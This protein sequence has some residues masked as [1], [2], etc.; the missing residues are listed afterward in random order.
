MLCLHYLSAITAQNRRSQP[1]PV[2]IC[3]TFIILV[4]SRG[5]LIWHLL[6]LWSNLFSLEHPCFWNPVDVLIN[7]SDFEVHSAVMT[8]VPCRSCQLKRAM[9]ISRESS[10]EKEITSSDAELSRPP[11]TQNAYTSWQS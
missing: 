7:G 4:M 10:G 11:G 2:L 5:F 9:D 3:V 8:V 6:S 1:L